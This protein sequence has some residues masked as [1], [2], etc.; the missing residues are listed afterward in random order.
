VFEAPVI[1]NF[2]VTEQ[3]ADKWAY[4]IAENILGTK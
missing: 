1:Y 3:A 2:R 4:L